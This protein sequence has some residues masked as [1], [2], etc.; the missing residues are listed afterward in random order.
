MISSKDNWL[1]KAKIIIL[2]HGVHN[3]CRLPSS[4]WAALTEHQKLAYKQQKF[5]SHS[6]G[7]SKSKIKVPADL[8]SAEGHFLIC[9]RLSFHC[10]LTRWVGG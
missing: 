4:I 7:G 6:F 9:R 1:F 8:V 2:N 3:V 5:I 10:V